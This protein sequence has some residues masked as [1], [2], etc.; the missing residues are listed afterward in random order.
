MGL[1]RILHAIQKMWTSHSVSKGER[2]YIDAFVRY[3]ESREDSGD[4]AVVRSLQR[5]LEHMQRYFKVETTV[6]NLMHDREG[7]IQYFQNQSFLTQYSST[8]VNFQAYVLPHLKLM[9]QNTLRIVAYTKQCA[10][11]RQQGA[12]TIP[13]QTTLE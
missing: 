6:K 9:R 12:N 8:Q 5:Y 1:Q 13:A 11:F 2:K 10:R 7:L 3:Q 4:R